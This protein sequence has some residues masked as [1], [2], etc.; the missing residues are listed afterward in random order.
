MKADLILHDKVTEPESIYDLAKML[1]RNLKKIKTLKRQAYG[2]KDME[3]FK[4]KIM[5]IHE[6]RY[7]LVGSTG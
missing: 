1:H 6:T 3:F 2:F 5:A 4:I 7:A